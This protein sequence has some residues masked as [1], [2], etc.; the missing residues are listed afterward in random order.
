MKFV[1][2]AVCSALLGVFLGTGLSQEA[3]V[4][5]MV[6]IPAGEFWMG[7]V[8]NWLLDEISW[9]ERDRMDDRPAHLVYTDPYYVDKFEVTN[10]DYVKFVDATRRK[11]PHHWRKSRPSEI[12]LKKPVY[13]VTWDD[14]AA[15][16]S[17]AGKRLPT[18]AEWERAARG[19]VEK[20]LYPWGDQL[21]AGRGGRGG[22]PAPAATATA[23]T[24][25]AAA[26]APPTRDETGKK[27]H[28]GF[29]NG[30]ADVGSYPPNGFGLHD[31]TGN[32]W[33][34]TSDLYQRNYYSISPEKNP[35]GPSTGTYRVL[36]G[37]AWSDSDDR[38]LGLHY[39]NYA[40]PN[41]KAPTIGFR[42][43]KSV[44]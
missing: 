22:P 39:R 41:V 40:D 31:M 9:L 20:S 18:E 17:W 11:P 43:A 6:R 34:W 33:E 2:M 30:P 3:D 26:E 21:A 38:M 36:R 35:T 27:A 16:C 24:P 19:G 23:A 1:R 29:P 28:Y 32:V 4:P 14:A 12:Q 13:N 37:A 25:G 5:G 10:E 15:Y 44:N 8:H 7:R 42:C